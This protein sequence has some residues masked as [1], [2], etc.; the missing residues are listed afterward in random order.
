MSNRWVVRMRGPTILLLALLGAC[1]DSTGPE[2]GAPLADGTYRIA[3]GAPAP[4]LFIPASMFAQPNITFVKEGG[5]LSV[6]SADSGVPH[7]APRLIQILE[8]EWNVHFDVNGAGGNEYFAVRLR[9][10]SCTALGVALFR[11]GSP[12]TVSC[13]IDRLN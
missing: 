5:A 6:T 12:W 10:A 4:S 8:D 13:S 3:L 7:G 2:D 9:T 11:S 1:G